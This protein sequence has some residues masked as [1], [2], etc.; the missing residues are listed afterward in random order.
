[1]IG[2]SYASAQGRISL[3]K[4]DEVFHDVKAA[5]YYADAVKWAREKQHRQW[6]R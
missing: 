3:E 5:A 4:T 2:S 6:N 1:M